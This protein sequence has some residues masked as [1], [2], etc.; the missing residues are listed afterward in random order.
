[1]EEPLRVLVAFGFG[2]LLV[3]LRL[4]AERFGAAEYDASANGGPLAVARRRLAWYALGIA[5]IAAILVIHPGPARPARPQLGDRRPGDPGGPRVSVRSG[6]PR[7]SVSRSSATTASA[8]RRPSYPS[9]LVNA[10]LTAFIDEATFRAI[11]LGLPP[12][13]RRR[14]SSGDRHPGPRLHARDADR[15]ARPRPLPAGAHPRDRPHRR[16]AD[17]RDRGHRRGVPRP[18][19][20]AL[21]G[22]RPAPVPD[23]A[24][25]AMENDAPIGQARRRPPEGSRARAPRG[26]SSA[27]S[28]DGR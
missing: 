23:Q 6:S 27:S 5:L 26:A 19:H 9:A 16:L 20:H 28:V 14:A 21:R 17:G 22:L 12:R 18:R 1:M 24:E 4:D 3:M 13:G 25:P 11:L 10:I 15:R 7:R 8:S 2:L